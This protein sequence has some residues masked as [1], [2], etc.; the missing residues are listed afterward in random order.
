MNRESPKSEM[1][2][3]FPE[4]RKQ[5]HAQI[6]RETADRVETNPKPSEA[7]IN[8]GAFREMLEP[9]VRD[10][11]FEMRKKGY[12]TESSGF[13]GTTGEVQSMDGYFEIDAET[14]QALR[15]VGVEVLRDQGFGPKYAF[16]RFSPDEPSLEKIKAKWDEVAKLLPDRGRQAEPSIS[17]HAEEFLTKY[18]PDRVD[19]LQRITELRQQ[20]DKEQEKAIVKKE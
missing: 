10:A 16:L 17:G 18:V 15:G 11:V 2:E 6:E 19:V 3:A 5:S 1:L 9:Q 4:L 20:H 14:E 8:A 13:G 7:E 12:A